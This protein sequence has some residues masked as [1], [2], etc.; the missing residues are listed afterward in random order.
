[1]SVKLIADSGASKCSW[2]IL[3]NKRK[4]TFQTQGISP[5]HLS[6]EEIEAIIRAQVLSEINNIGIDEIYFYG[7]G[8]AAESNKKL[9]KKIFSKVFPQGKIIHINTDLA[10]SAH[11]T[12]GTAKGIVSILGTGSGIAY[13]NGK[14]IIKEQ[15]G[16]GYILGDEGS[17]TYLGRKVIQYYLY[18]TFD[19]D[20]MHDFKQK[21]QIDKDIILQ[22]VYRDPFAAKYIASFTEFLSEHRGHYMIENIIEDGLNDF[23]ISHVYKFRESWIYP[24]HFTGGIA[25]AFKDVLKELCKNYELEFGKIIQYPIEGLINFY[26]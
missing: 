9:L 22:H 20:L 21:Y 11:A 8:L 24:L 3:H 10:A 13:F 16:I 25:F 15:N 19:D 18:H 2:A 4:K 17:G 1:M 23:F 14:K 5:Y 26:K 12:C 6:A 7:T